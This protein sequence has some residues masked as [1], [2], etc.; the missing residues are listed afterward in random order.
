MKI[1]QGPSSRSKPGTKSCVLT[2]KRSTGLDIRITMTM[3]SHFILQP[4]TTG[5]LNTGIQG[6]AILNTAQQ[7][8]HLISTALLTCIDNLFVFYCYDVVYPWQ[9]FK[10]RHIARASF[11]GTYI[12]YVIQD[13]N[14]SY[15]VLIIRCIEYPVKLINCNFKLIDVSFCDSFNSL[16][17]SPVSKFPVKGNLNFNLYTFIYIQFWFNLTLKFPNFL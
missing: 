17:P 3:R 5:L 8:T 9:P 10:L 13:I 7:T 16:E 12:T 6:R 15:F 2:V 4:A 14:Q 1:I 11:H